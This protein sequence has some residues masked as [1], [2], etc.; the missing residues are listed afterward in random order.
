MNKIQS[1]HRDQKYRLLCNQTLIS[2][3]NSMS[4]PSPSPSESTMADET[5]KQSWWNRVVCLVLLHHAIKKQRDNCLL[6]SSGQ[7]RCGT[8]V[9]AFRPTTKMK[10]L[11]VLLSSY[12]VLIL[13]IKF[14]PSLRMRSIETENKKKT[15]NK[16]TTTANYELCGGYV[17]KQHG[18]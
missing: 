1:V 5:R 2:Y 3:A 18:P 17:S 14:I 6:S 9:A 7:V 13:Y 11:G 4:F 8:V 16:N 15:K 10:S 12:I